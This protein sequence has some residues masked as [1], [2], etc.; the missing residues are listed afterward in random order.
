MI[1]EIF[2]IDRNSLFGN[3]NKLPWHYRD[4]LQYFKEKTL[5]KK[6]L[7]G[8]GTFKSLLAIN[9][10][11]LPKRTSVIATLTDYTYDG[12]EVVHDAISYLNKMRDKEDI[13]VIGGKGI[14][15]LTY[16]MADVLYIT[17]IDEDHEGDI[18]L[19]L[20]LSGFDLVE[21]VPKGVLYFRKYVKKHLN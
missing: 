8:E 7:M 5:G 11:P 15:E 19:N 13:Y 21:E 4:D 18:Y 10:K 1:Y 12:V 3:G 9:G 20:D 14:I 2:A 17:Y 16:K 6:C